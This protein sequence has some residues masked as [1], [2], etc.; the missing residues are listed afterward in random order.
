MQNT[1]IPIAD[2][3]LRIQDAHNSQAFVEIFTN[4][5]GQFQYIVPSK[6]IVISV[7]APAYKTEAVQAGVA[8]ALSPG[9]RRQIEIKLPHQ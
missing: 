5:D 1:Q 6:P 3:K 2:A 9:E 7:S 8:L 4:R